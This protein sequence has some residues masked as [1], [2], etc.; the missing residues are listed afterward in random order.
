MEVKSRSS[1][2]TASAA[3]EMVSPRRPWSHRAACEVP[4]FA[5]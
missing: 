3:S 2:R 5:V 1:R 4:A